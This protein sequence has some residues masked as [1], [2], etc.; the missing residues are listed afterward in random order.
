MN[1]VDSPKNADPPDA[2]HQPSSPPVIDYEGSDYE[3][4][5]WGRGERA[6]EDQAERIAL[7]KLLP[8]A[9]RRLVEFGAAFGRLA[10]LYQGYQQ[11]LLV[12]YSRSLL[13][14]AQQRLGRDG[15]FVYVAA[16]IYHLPLAPAVADT[17]VM[18]RVM[19][20]LADVPA[21]LAQIRQAIA[22]GGAFIAE[23]A[24]KRHLKAIA[25]YA[26][27]QQDW[28]PFDTEPYEFVPLNY[29]FHPS[30]MAAQLEAAGFA[31]DRDLAVSHFRVPALK[32]LVPAHYLA[33]A[34]GAVQGVGALWKLT[35]S[36]FV[37]CQVPGPP[38]GSLPETLFR[39][40]ACGGALAGGS[41][42]HDCTACGQRWPVRDGIHDFKEPLAA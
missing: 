21:A 5:F 9:G 10:D 30:W 12:D 36:V 7:R 24:S 15:R 4:R 23:Y 41:E 31:V 17:A 32:R 13:R 35:P 19:H 29:D 18:V 14:Q 40:P 42:S 38:P 1:S 25:R 27:R 16:D 34:D 33:A 22:P 28:S 6:Y 39:C 37:R 11:V 3:E 20:H 8:A 26:L 2:G